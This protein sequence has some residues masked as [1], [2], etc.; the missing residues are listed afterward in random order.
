MA[1]RTIVYVDGFN[2]Y[3]GA[4]RGGPH[5]WLDLQ[6]YFTLLRPH[7]R[8]VQIHYFTAFLTGARQENQKT[9]LKAL[10]T[11]PLVNI[12]LGQFKTKRVL[13]SVPGCTFGGSRWFDTP[14]EKRSDVNIGVQMVDDAYQ[15]RCDAMV[16]VSGDSDL[17]PAVNMV[18]A[19]FPKMFV[20]VYVP[21]RS[22]IRG[23]AVQLRAAADRNKTLPL[24]LLKHAQFPK[25][26]PDG[27]GGV[28]QK[29]GAW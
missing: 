5:K 15:N 13:C 1:R 29:P 14:E 27:A 3:Y 4:V 9:Y 28:I 6:R 16:L 24:A 17:V 2:L 22:Q 26:V 23:A 20:V 18:K 8:I 11:L 10:A 12:V 19:Q 25:A 7:D 21:A